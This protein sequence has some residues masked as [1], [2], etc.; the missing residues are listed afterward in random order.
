MIY[1]STSTINRDSIEECVK[2][3]VRLDIRNIELSGGVGYSDDI[4][5]SLKSLKDKYSLNYLVH[6]YFPP[7]KEDFVLNIAST[8]DNIRRRSL[9]VIKSSIDLARILDIDFY[10]VH[11]GYANH[12]LPGIEGGYFS[13]GRDEGISRGDAMSIMHGT[14]LEVK[15]YASKYHIKIGIENLFPFGNSPEN[16]LLSTPDDIFGF[17]DSIADD[18]SF[19]FLLD[20]GHLFISANYFGFEIDSFIEH[21]KTK[22][23]HKVLEIHLSGNDGKLDQHAPLSPDS[24]QLK[25]ARKFDLDTVP[26]TLECRGLDPGDVLKQYNIAKKILGRNVNHGS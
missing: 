25:T 24:W 10:S 20:L 9:E 5:E 3:L 19:G 13:P 2:E 1:I 4:P 15:E 16:T 17:L 12:F 26:V 8:D 22:Y 14:L 6:N 11:A 18:E 7:P 21:L 23:H